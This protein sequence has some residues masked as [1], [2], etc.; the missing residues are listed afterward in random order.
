M[1]TYDVRT[2]GCQMNVH[3][4]ERLRGLLEEAGYAPVD[5]GA[6]ADVAIYRSDSDAETM[7]RTPRYVLKAGV[8]V[9]EDGQIRR[10][11]YG[12]TLQAT[13]EYDRG[14][15]RSVRALLQA[16]GT[17]R[18]EDYVIDEDEVAG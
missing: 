15:E 5:P 4:S 11:V 2:H 9:A 14:V 13:P 6:D 8:V 7:F 10:E 1:P 12:R 16:D 18:I 3:D 17:L